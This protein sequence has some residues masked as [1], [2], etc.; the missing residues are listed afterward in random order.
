MITKQYNNKRNQKQ[1]R[2]TKHNIA[3]NMF[4]VKRGRDKDKTLINNLKQYNFNFNVKQNYHLT[5]TVK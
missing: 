1:T 4:K 3:Q 2:E 5:I